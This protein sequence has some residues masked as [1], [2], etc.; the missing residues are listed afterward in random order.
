MT[1]V[2]ERVV[3]SVVLAILLWFHNWCVSKRGKNCD[4][5]AW[6]M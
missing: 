2:H 3:A 4:F 6:V 5:L 1:Q